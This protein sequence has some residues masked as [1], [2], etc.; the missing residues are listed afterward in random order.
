MKHCGGLGV[1]LHRVLRGLQEG[2][3]RGLEIGIVLGAIRE[4]L[5]GQTIGR[6]DS[7]RIRIGDRLPLIVPSTDLKS[8][9]QDV[10]EEERRDDG[11]H[12]AEGRVEHLLR[13][14]PLRAVARRNEHADETDEVERHAPHE[15]RLVRRADAVVELPV[16]AQEEARLTPRRM[17]SRHAVPRVIE[18]DRGE[19]QEQEDD[20]EAHPPV[21]RHAARERIG[22]ETPQRDGQTRHVEQIDHRAERRS[23]PAIFADTQEERCA[24]P[25]E[26][27]TEECV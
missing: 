17:V 4:P 3:V 16:L 25:S 11:D 10:D 8:G 18:L 20:R 19:H 21:P 13:A 7:Q 22:D 12:A 6:V 26:D 5:R 2:A 14:I 15:P 24:H 1:R 9:E 27:Q 23:R